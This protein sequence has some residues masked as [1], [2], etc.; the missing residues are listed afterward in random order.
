MKY[1]KSFE[2][3]GA[4][5][6]VLKLC[7]ILFS[8]VRFLINMLKKCVFHLFIISH[9]M[10]HVVVNLFAVHIAQGID[11]EDK[12]LA[13]WM[14]RTGRTKGGQELCPSH[15]GSLPLC[16]CAFWDLVR[17]LKIQLFPTFHFSIN[18][19]FIYDKNY[20]NYY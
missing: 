8:L 5:H 9:F 13:I 12:Q 17:K 14:T 15:A 1:Y 2:T 10:S 11:G 6:M 7:F 19:I 3:K 20:L 18:F 16:S 4:A